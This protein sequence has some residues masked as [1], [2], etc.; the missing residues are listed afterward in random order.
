[1]DARARFLRLRLVLGLPVLAAAGVHAWWTCGMAGLAGTVAAVLATR[2][3]ALPEALSVSAVEPRE[4]A[5]ETHDEQTKI[6][7]L[8]DPFAIPPPVL[9]DLQAVQPFVET[10]CGQI[11]GIQQDV[12]QGVVAVVDR[13]RSIDAL[14]QGQ[15]D[16]IHASVAGAD[17][18]RQ[19]A[20]VPGEI[21]ARLAHMLAER[22]RIIER[23][24]A[25][26]QA[27]ADEFQGLR[28]SVEVI[29]TIA[30]KAFFLSVNAAVEAQHRGAAG[31]AFGLIA[32]EM[33]SLA[34]QTADS[35]REVGVNINGFAERMHAS[36]TAAM[37]DRQK[38]AGGLDQLIDELRGAQAR[39][40]AGGADLDRVIQTLDGGHREIVGAL[41]EILGSLQFQD[42]MRQRLEQVFH[43]LRELEDLVA[44]STSGAPPVRSLLDI[45][46]DQRQ[47]YVMESQ[48]H[49]H[50]AIVAGDETPHETDR[51]IELF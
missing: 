10:L 47:D 51:K 5:P 32:S 7:F 29:S 40:V 20:E 45:L 27:L 23:N 12:A 13:V 46:E 33:R 9:A 1:M 3:L 2:L 43:A 11:E 19:A 6:A 15:R 18:I 26:L 24:F 44:R 31:V 49:V 36:I 35:A 34:R 8:H 14:S 4:D 50:S 16:R 25:G 48:R 41:S 17:T 38:E 28:S 21:V 22:D 30:D 39:L 42:V 37:P